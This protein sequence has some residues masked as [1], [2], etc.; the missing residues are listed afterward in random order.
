MVDETG[1]RE[2]DYY[3]V[4]G[5]RMTATDEEIRTAHRRLALEWH[6]DKHPGNP[7]VA[8]KFLKIQRAAEVLR[9]PDARYEYDMEQC[10]YRFAAEDYLDKVS[11]HLTLTAS[12]LGLGTQAQAVI[13]QWAV[14]TQPRSFLTAS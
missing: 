11:P 14:P 2:E 10:I 12:G 9:D 1:V 4:L 3:A 5:L 13:M 7:L 8:Q 6:P